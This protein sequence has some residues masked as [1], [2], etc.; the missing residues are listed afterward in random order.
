[1]IKTQQRTAVLEREEK[2]ESSSAMGEGE[3]RFE[4]GLWC[5]GLMRVAQEWS[6]PRSPSLAAVIQGVAER[7]GLPPDLFEIFV[8][9][10]LGAL[11]PDSDGQ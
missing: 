1:M 3:I 9:E 5:I 11:M 2:A 7:R 6:D 4:E 8:A 10:R